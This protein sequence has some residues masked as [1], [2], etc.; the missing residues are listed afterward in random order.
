MM[1]M[2]YLSVMLVFWFI[3]ETQTWD[4]CAAS[5]VR[6]LVMHTYS[7][8]IRTVHGSTLQ[9]SY[10][11]VEFRMLLVF[12]NHVQLWQIP[13]IFLRQALFYFS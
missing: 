10:C 13:V 1:K 8:D 2:S 6:I 11:H 3:S 12:L 9:P 5:E 7:R 4:E